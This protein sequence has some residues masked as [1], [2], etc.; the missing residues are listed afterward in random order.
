[1]SLLAPPRRFDPNVLEMMDRPNQDPKLLRED[2]F[3]LEKLNQFLGGY[4]IP[5]HHLTKFLPKISHR[6]AEI[7]DLATG[8]ADVPRKIVQWARQKNIEIRVTAADFN[9]QILEIARENA[10]NYPEIRIEKHNLLAL[11][12]APKSFDVVLNSLALHHFAERDAIEILRRIND[13]A[14]VAFIV[15]D[16]S[17]SHLAIAMSWLLTRTLTTNPLSRH[18][19]VMSC[20]RAFTKTEFSQ[21]AR[22]AGMKNFQIRRYGVRIAL[23]GTP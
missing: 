21:L 20:Q 12:F 2:L 22:A 7:L 14:R 8:S 4:A 23:V 17:R 10:K 6:P 9:D 11:P 1:M 18:D 19:A 13:I 3:F 16:L 15:N 5:I